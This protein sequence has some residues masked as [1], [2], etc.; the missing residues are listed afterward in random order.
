MTFSK[1]AA[2]LELGNNLLNLH[3]DWFEDLALNC[4]STFPYRRNVLDIIY[5]APEPN[6]SFV[7]DIATGTRYMQREGSIT[8]VPLRRTVRYCHTDDVKLI[9]VHFALEFA[10]GFDLF[11]DAPQVFQFDRPEWVRRFATLGEQ[12]DDI[13]AMLTLRSL[14]LALCQE[15]YPALAP[16]PGDA[17]RY[18]NLLADAAR[19]IRA[20]LTVEDLAAAAGCRRET[21]ARNFRRD[22]GITPTAW[23]HRALADRIGAL[24]CDRA[25]TLENIARKLG[26]SSEFY[27]SAFFKRETGMSPRAYRNAGFLPHKHK[28]RDSAAP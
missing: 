7:E 23:L 14:V 21:F 25:L 26:F 4:D 22:L 19:N 1:R 28:M 18:A 16:R 9:S 11:A 15:C 6:S 2:A 13:G 12:Q 10:N 8:L 3:I 5:E 27:L 24:L 20:G 17:L